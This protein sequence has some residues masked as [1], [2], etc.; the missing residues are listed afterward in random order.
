MDERE[1][2]AHVDRVRR[3]QA[4]REERAAS[5]HVPE[6]KRSSFVLYHR[7]GWEA[8]ERILARGFTDATGT[9]MTGEE[10][11]GVFV[12]DVP[13]DTGQGAASNDVLLRVHIEADAVAE[14]EWVQEGSYREW[15]VPA[16]LLNGRGMVEVVDED[17]ED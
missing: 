8:A 2:Q 3:L 13:L 4:W 9:Y 7:T 17:A 6:A 10:H 15:C 1:I 12:S 14:F 16:A 11:T 5:T